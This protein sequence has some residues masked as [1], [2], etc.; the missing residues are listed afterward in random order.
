MRDQNITAEVVD[1]KSVGGG[2]VG[3]VKVKAV[4]YVD[5]TTDVNMEINNTVS[6]H[7]DIVFF[8]KK[9]KAGLHPDKC[10]IL[11]INYKPTESVPSLY[12][13]GVKLSAVSESKH[14]GD[15]FNT[16][17]N[18]LALVEE[19]R[20]K[21]K[22]VTINILAT[23]SEVIVGKH[24]LC[25]MLLLYRSVFLHSIL[26]NSRAWSNMTQKEEDVLAET[27]MRFLKRILKL[28]SSASN[29]GVL[30]ELGALPIKYEIH[31]RRLCFLWHIATLDQ[32]DPVKC[33]YHAQKEFPFEKNWGNEVTVLCKTYGIEEDITKIKD[34]SKEAWKTI[35]NSAVT[36]KGFEV[37]RKSNSSLSKTK[38]LVYD[39]LEAQRYLY[40]QPS[41]TACLLLRLRIKSTVC[42]KDQLSSSEVL[43]NCR[44]CGLVPEHIQHVLNCTKV[45]NGHDP[46]VDTSYIRGDVD[47]YQDF[48]AIRVR[49]NRFCELVKQTSKAK[50]KHKDK[51]EEIVENSSQ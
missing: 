16:K 23:C 42:L 29:I 28:P 48:S 17:G 32:N 47:W 6:S 51:D 13:D 44:L 4:V 18:Y 12:V 46:T 24:Y 22:S 10:F 35:V 49:Y 39:C 31:K 38:D 36:I 43:P 26:C 20:K 11:P 27:Q 14:L 50:E 3:Q 19:R 5:D 30:L 8:S 1:E 33:M 34:K 25:S 9:K 40:I 7:N 45:I 41:D 37:M 15:V 2:H 21:G